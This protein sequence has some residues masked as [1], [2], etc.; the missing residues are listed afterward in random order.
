MPKDLFS[1]GALYSGM[2]GGIGTVIEDGVPVTLGWLDA[3]GTPQ[4]KVPDDKTD[5]VQ[6]YYFTRADEETPGEALNLGMTAQA[7]ASELR[8]R[9]RTTS[10]RGSRW[11][12]SWRRQ[13]DNPLSAYLPD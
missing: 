6:K 4:L 1:A 11:S 10:A 9:A 3:N 7:I 8:A 2:R 5:G 13:N 12:E